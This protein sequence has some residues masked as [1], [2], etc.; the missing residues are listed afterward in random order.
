M[1]D[2]EYGD[3]RIHYEEY[4]A[5]HPVLL[6]APGGMRSA[7]AFWGGLPGDPPRPAPWPDPRV[8]LTD[9]FRVIAM[10]QR[11]AGRSSAPVRA[12]DGWHSYTE[13]HLALL[14]HLGIERCHV[15]G[16][17]IGCSYAF[18]LCQERPDL[19]TAAVM[20]NPIGKTGDNGDMFR[21][22]FDDWIGELEVDEATAVSFRER[23]FGGDFVFSV[24]RDAVRGLATPLLVLAGHD[25]FHPTAV[26]S[27]IASLAADAELMLDWSDRAATA[28]RVRSF[29]AARTD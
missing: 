26:A 15:I 10:D 11:N 16:G 28:G 19:V 8:E 18:A 5:G 23:M 17:C 12:A 21:R 25:D 27:E 1:P 7:A 24:D 13:D 14:D 22:M 6:F 29:L 3:V 9:R 4:G 2:F 20:Q